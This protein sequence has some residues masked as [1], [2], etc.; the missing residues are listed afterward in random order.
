MSATLFFLLPIGMLVVVWS[1]CFVGCSYPTFMFDTYSDLVLGE[2]NLLAYWPLNELL[3]AVNAPG[4]DGTA[5]DLSKK[6]HDGTYTI[7]P[8]YP[9]GMQAVAQSKALNPPTLARGAS[10]VPGDANSSTNKFAASA[11]F[12][13]GYVSIPW[14][15][16]DWPLL[17]Q[18]TFEAWILPKWTGS[19]NLWVVFS[20]F[21]NNTGFRILINDKNHWEFVIGTG[22]GNMPNANDTMVP[23]D[24]TST[25]PTYVAV[26]CDSTSGI[27]NLW[28]NPQS[29]GDTPNPPPPPATWTSPAP[30]GYVAADPSQLMAAFIGAGAN[31]QP[32]RTPMANPQGAPLYPFQGLIQSVALYGGLLDPGDIQSHFLSG[33]G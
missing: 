4:P 20:A 6:G 14:S 1:V 12:E 3:Q 31:E 8:D 9:S 26:T 24:P 16:Q 28:I 18:F 13:G 29:Q 33:A 21:V 7:P 19:Q 27:I 10:I 17:N 32:L 5:G 11:D 22:P 2:S 23:I 25:T 15:T 30:T